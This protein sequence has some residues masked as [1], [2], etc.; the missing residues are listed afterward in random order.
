MVKESSYPLDLTN[1]FV[2]KCHFQRVADVPDPFETQVNF[3][4]RV[5]RENL[6]E[7]LQ[8]DLRAHTQ[9]DQ[10]LNL[11]V[12]MVGLFERRDGTP[13][14]EHKMVEEFVNQRAL[15]MLWAMMNQFIKQVTANM[16]MSPLNFKSPAEF[17]LSLE[18]VEI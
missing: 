7:R 15:F 10:P 2:I 4:V 1:A 8:V 18:D 5:R 6:P 11:E 17:N 14:L 3:Q 16:G 13:G 9:G 12:E